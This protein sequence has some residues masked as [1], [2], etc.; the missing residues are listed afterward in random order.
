M[1]ELPEVETYQRY[2]RQA[3]LHQKID[4]VYVETAK[5]IK[6]GSEKFRK[7][8]VGEKFEDS[9]RQGKYFF[10]R[11]TSGKSV[12]F[13]FGMTGSLQYK[14]DEPPPYSR[15]RFHF[16]NG[17][18]LAFVIKRKFGW[19]DLADDIGD[20]IK[21]KGLGPD[22]LQITKEDFIDL[23]S[24]KTS[25]IKTAL[26]DQSIISGIGNLYADET[27]FQSG[28]LP[29]R[30]CNSI[31]AAKWS[32]IYHTMQRVLKVVTRHKADF[33][34]VPDH[35]LLNHREKGAACPKCGGQV[36]HLTINGRTTYY[37]PSCQH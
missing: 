25:R 11:L 21:K 13:H 37:C 19:I 2:F 31:D 34:E 20:Y 24:K 3:A 9:Y 5:L 26:M 17:Y 14:K 23:F 1:P 28:V 22:A 10:G 18:F 6:T 8:V 27:L 15:V 12:V 36:E 32:D 35:Y 4:D 7:A 33:E 16:D 30:S 29:D